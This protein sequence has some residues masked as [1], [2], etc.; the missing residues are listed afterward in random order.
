MADEERWTKLEQIVRRVVK[1]EIA[2][3]GK[4]PKIELVNGS[5]VGITEEQ[6]TAWKAAY[7]AVDL[8]GE[9]KRAAAW[10][11]SNP[12]LAP[13]SQIGRFLNTWFSRTQNTT[14]LR[15]IPGG[16]VEQGP[17]KKLCAYCDAVA[18]AKYGST[19][20][21]GAHSRDALDGVPVPIMRGVVAKPVAGN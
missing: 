12:H 21:C 2:A 10:I 5:W 13:K 18:T 3:L 8:D 4:K 15:S 20:A 7:G 19:W 17:G 1:E 14:S 9:L 16:K 6:M 11:I